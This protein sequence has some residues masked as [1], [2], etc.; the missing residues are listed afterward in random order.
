MIM[1]RLSFLLALICI[2]VLWPEVVHCQTKPVG[3]WIFDR[4]NMRQSIT[5]NT[6]NN[7]ATMDVSLEFAEEYPHALVLDKTSS[8]ISITGVDASDLPVRQISVQAWV[9]LDSA[10]QWGGIIGYFQDNGSYEKGWLLGYTSEQFSFAIS[11]AGTLTYLKSKT[12]FKEGR[13]YHVVGTYDGAKMKIYINGRLESTSVTQ[14]GN[15]DYPPKA[16]YTIGAYRDDNELYPCEGKLHEVRVYDK[17]LTEQEIRADYKAKESLTLEALS[18]KVPPYLQ[19]SSPE[20]ATIIWE[21]NNLCRPTLEYGRDGK[22]N[23]NVTEAVPK[24]SHKMTVTGLE[25]G[26]VYSYRIK[27]VS[28]DF[29]SL[30]KVYEFD[31]AFNYTISPIVEGH[32]PYSNDEAGKLYGDVARQI[33]SQTGISKGYCLVYG[34]VTGQLAYEL[35]KSSELRVICVDEDAD[36]L[37]EMRKLFRRAGVYGQRITTRHVE[38]LSKL[39]IT[40]CFANLIVSEHI[41]ALGACPGDAG[42]LHRV[43]Q[44]G[45]VAY[46]GQP[47]G[48]AKRLSKSALEGWLKAAS[49]IYDGAEPSSGTWVKITRQ[50]PTGAGTWTHEYGNANNSAYGGETLEGVRGTDDLKVQW[51]GRPGADFGIDRNPRMPAPL[52]VSGRLYHQGLNR[53]IALDAYNGAILWSAEI[54]DLR[55]VNLPRDASNWCADDKFLYVAVNDKCWVFD[56]YS[57]QRKA[58]L[59]LSDSQQGRT[60]D[61]G[62]VARSGELLYG[63]SV[64]SNSVYTDFWGSASWYDGKQGAGTGKICSDNI[65]ACVKDTGKTVWEYQGGIII[66]ATIAIGD[67]KVYFVDS[68][69]PE[70]KNL[71]TGRIDSDKLWSDQHLVAINAKT[72]EK[73]WEKKI[74]TA[75]GI[76]VFFLAYAD[77]SIIISSSASGQYYLYSY[78]AGDGRQQWQASHKWPGDN[79]GGHMQHPVIAGGTVYLEPCGYDLK[80]GK[81]VTNKVGRHEGCATYAAADGVLIY[82]GKGR[83][84]ALWDIETGKVSS[85]TNLRPS[86]WLSVIPAGGM[87]LAPEGGGGCSCGNWLEAS[88]GFAPRQN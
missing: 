45:G 42:E 11:T 83:C 8:A 23:D 67:G 49:I 3:W 24:T 16:F 57:G 58:S 76:V 59:A 37:A 14:S 30:S 21:T 43:L 25:S 12:H 33:I 80:T 79:H 19:F 22:L 13:W 74:D 88:V 61:W 73:L 50:A 15:I 36:R 1:K 52:S 75:D 34:C 81:L 17:V 26:E 77:G 4:A 55:R 40:S 46:L 32:S 9:S 69:N 51:I 28:D 82:R 41:V 5:D 68:R 44:P 10:A 54:P 48:A 20:S 71:Q 66:N 56:G 72:G 27:T 7:D 65:F 38:S 60:H 85:W 87:V 18:F 84:I 86:C 78:G 2:A 39:P 64:K 35:A 47:A 29:E 63:S 62:Y 53:L 31:T 70:V 6:G